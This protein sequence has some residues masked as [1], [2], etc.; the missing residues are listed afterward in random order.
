MVKVQQG[1]VALE[2]G[3]RRGSRECKFLASALRELV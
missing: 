1:L 3:V 2:T